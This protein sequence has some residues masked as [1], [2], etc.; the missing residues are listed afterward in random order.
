M[1]IIVDQVC[2]SDRQFITTLW[3]EIFWVTF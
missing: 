2:R 1:D 3:R